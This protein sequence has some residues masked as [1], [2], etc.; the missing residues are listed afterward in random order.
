LHTYVDKIGSGVDQDY[1]IWNN[2]A[3][4]KQWDPNY[5]FLIASDWIDGWGSSRILVGLVDN[6]FGFYICI[7]IVG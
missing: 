5:D 7:K 4:S 1:M 3:N 6:V 2:P